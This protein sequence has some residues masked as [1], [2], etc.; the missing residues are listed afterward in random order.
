M[1]VHEAGVSL[2]LAELIF[3]TRAGADLSQEQLAAELGVSQADVDAWET[4]A[5][6]PRVDVLDRLARVCGRRLHIAIEI[7]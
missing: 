6:A 4:G 3:E 2:N 5:E 7:N 1:E